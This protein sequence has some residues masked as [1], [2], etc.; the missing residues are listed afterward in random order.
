MM[1]LGMG[2]FALD[3]APADANSHRELAGLRGP[4]P[5]CALRRAAAL[6]PQTCNRLS[7]DGIEDVRLALG[8]IP[9]ADIASISRYYARGSTPVV[10]L[11]LHDERAYLGRWSLWRRVL[12][13][14]ST[15]VNC[16]PFSI[17]Y[18]F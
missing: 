12:G 7:D 2:V 3:E 18:S 1:A 6:R 14:L 8:F 13:R 15:A 5:G 11:W 17:T 16:S 9:W 10:E 4:D